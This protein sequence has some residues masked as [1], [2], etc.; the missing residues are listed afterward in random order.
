MRHAKAFHCR[1][2]RRRLG[3]RRGFSLVE[4]LT[5]LV[6]VAT[7][8]ALALP[9]YS[10]VRQRFFDTTALTDVVNAGR[11][12]A[13]LESSVAFAQ[14]VRGPGPIR[15]LPGPLVSNGTTVFVRRTVDRKGGVTYLVRGSHAQG[16]GAVFFFENGKV[17]A[18]GAG[19]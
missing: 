19:L 8:T 1:T 18:Q 11:A 17:Y 3:T 10:R 6:V 16:S 7:L 15:L 4:L 14:T 2:E 5:V 13:A 12:L 9:A